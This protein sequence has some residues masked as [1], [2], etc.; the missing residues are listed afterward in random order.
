MKKTPIVES[1]G[2]EC[3]WP[4]LEYQYDVS[5]EELFKEKLDIKV[6]DKNHLTSDGLIGISTFSLKN[7]AIIGTFGSDINVPINLI[8]I[9]G[10]S[11]G[12]LILKC[13]LHKKEELKT[14]KVTNGFINGI[15]QIKKIIGIDFAGGGMFTTSIGELSTYLILKIPIV[16]EDSKIEEIPLVKG[17]D[18]KDP[19]VIK[20]EEN[21]S[22]WSG[23]TE[24]KTGNN[25]VWDFLDL[26][27]K[28]SNDLLSVGDVTVECWSKTLGGMGGDKLIGTGSVSMLSAGMIDQSTISHTVI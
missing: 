6:Y 26:K 12:K 14:L 18:K 16:K 15:I 17:K 10:K 21:T 1:G 8:G 2:E 7:L 28:V 3:S 9:K 5:V 23:K 24:I 22:F 25:P 19:I 27:S 20:K 11:A 4:N 13:G